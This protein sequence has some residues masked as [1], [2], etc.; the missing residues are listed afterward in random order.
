MKVLRLLLLLSGVVSLAS[1][2]FS[3]ELLNC[4]TN[5]QK[6]TGIGVGF[7]TGY[8]L[9]DVWL[10]PGGRLDVAGVGGSSSNSIDFA[11]GY[12]TRYRG[13]W[14]VG[15]SGPFLTYESQRNWGSYLLEGFAYG[16]GPAGILLTVYFVRK[17]M[18]VG[19]GD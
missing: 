6:F 12:L 2:S 13:V 5:S 16:C 17:G 7:G 8:T 3:V 9:V 14:S 19:V 11:D 18:R 15:A 10:P 1:P 4:T